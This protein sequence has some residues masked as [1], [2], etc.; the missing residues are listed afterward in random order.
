MA[1]K[2]LIKI[3]KDHEDFNN[4]RT[5]GYPYSNDSIVFIKNGK[6]YN[7]NAIY[8]NA[9]IDHLWVMGLRVIFIFFLIFSVLSKF[10][11]MNIYYLNDQKGYL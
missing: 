10:P 4:F 6:K 7:R 9:Y 1:F 5:N 8:Q 3:I 11:T 2:I